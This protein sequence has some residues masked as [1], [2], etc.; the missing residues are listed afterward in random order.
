MGIFSSIGSFFGPIGSIIGGVGDFALGGGFGGGSSD[1]NDHW[2]DNYQ[3]QKEFAQN[4]VRW[5]VNDA[6]EAG[7][8]PLA[9]MGMQPYNPS[10][11]AV[12]QNPKPSLSFLGEA[13][14]GIDR[15]ME[16]KATQEERLEAEVKRQEMDSLQLENQKLQNQYLQSQ[17]VDQQAK[18]SERAIATQQQVPS[19][20][21]TTRA[22]GAIISGQGDSSPLSQLTKTN[23]ATII[24]NDPSNVTA[25]AGSNPEIKWART[26]KDSYIS[27]RSQALEEALEDDK[28]GNLQ[29]NLRNKLVNPL[30]HP[31]TAAPPASYL[32]DKGKNTRFDYNYLT[33][34]WAPRAKDDLTWWERLTR[35]RE[36]YRRDPRGYRP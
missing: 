1:S 7:I 3:M 36:R 18:T 27:V 8:N 22:D 2:D 5:R 29:F 23:P 21:G 35:E 12:G 4:G 9:A 34:E 17:I 24:A 15:A 19:M 20:P 11:F 28:I 13:G 26:G 6:T 33:G 31:E 10:G 25:E 30:L 32:P 14:Q 16:A